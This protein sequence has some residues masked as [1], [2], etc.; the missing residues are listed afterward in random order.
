M[1]G[2]DDPSARRYNDAEVRLLLERAASLKGRAPAAA[3]QQ[4][5]TLAQ[6]EEI[7]AEAQIDV[8]RL[9]QA[10]QELDM[11]AIRPTGT[12]ARLAGAPLRLRVERTLPFELDTNEFG[13]LPGVISAFM[14]EDGT[15]NVIGR[16]FTWNAH[17][18]S[19]RRLEIRASVQKRR[20]HITVEERYTELAG[21]LF[22]GMLGGFGGGLG[23][24][25]GTSVGAALGSAAFAIAFPIAMVG[26]TYAAC[27]IGYRAYV[28]R[29]ANHVE[30]L[31]ERLVQDL[32]SVHDADSQRD[33]SA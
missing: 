20:T 29:R 31:C 14:G 32:T 6:L 15:S 16:T 2:N 13:A 8:A 30:A 17:S 10:A 21:G 27:R 25:V 12:G 28:R 26:G 33:E 22:G 7:A 23:I 3:R 4:G 1:A 9:R 18:A 24:G 5:L 11:G 19:G